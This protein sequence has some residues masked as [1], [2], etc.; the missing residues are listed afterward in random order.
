[1]LLVN[2]VA[3]HCVDVNDRGFNYG[4]GLFETLE[5]NDSHPVFLRSHLDRLKAG[6]KILKLPY[7]DEE[8]LLSEIKQLSTTPPYQSVLKII[9][10][11]GCGGRGYRQ[12]EQ[13]HPT[14]VLSIH[15]FPNFPHDYCKSGIYARFCDFRL[16]NN[17]ALAGIKHLNRLEQ[18]LARSEWQGDDFQ[19]G[20]MLDIDGFIVEGTMSNIFAVKNGLIYT[21]ELSNNGIKGVIRKL[22]L[23]H[24]GLYGLKVVLAKMTPQFLF[25][26]DEIFVTNSIIGVWP[27]VLLDQQSY[28]IGPIYDRVLQLIADCKQKDMEYAL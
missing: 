7:P 5:I 25:N 23:D 15:P 1:M 18:V 8:Q 19:E 22:I 10:T 17:P 14:R 2:G 26:A 12:P 6:C 27:V 16:G 4:D 24:A 28:P 3:Q 9:I 11:R 13:V 21:P 20:F